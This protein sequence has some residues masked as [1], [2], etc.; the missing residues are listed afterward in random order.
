MNAAEAETTV[1]AEVIKPRLNLIPRGSVPIPAQHLTAAIDVHD[2]ILYWLM[3]AWAD[4]FSGW[5]IDY[6]AWPDQRRSFWQHEEPSAGREVSPTSYPP[7][8]RN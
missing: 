8:A 6:G 4:G 5:V 2:E 3:A 1:P 7:S